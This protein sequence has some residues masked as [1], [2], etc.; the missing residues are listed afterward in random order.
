MSDSGTPREL[1]STIAYIGYHA[2]QNPDSIAVIENGREICFRDFHADLGRMV[3]ALRQLSIA[4]GQVVG[5]ECPQFYRHWLCLLACQ[6]VG[7]VS[8]SYD[9]A[10]AAP[11][12]GALAGADCILCSPGQAPPDSRRVTVMDRDRADPSRNP[13]ARR[14]ELRHHRQHETHGPSRAG[15]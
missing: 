8:F 11:L 12:A 15:A 10:E 2:A 3:T 6:A 9:P 5:I 14:V 7:V 13:A 4:P 1:T